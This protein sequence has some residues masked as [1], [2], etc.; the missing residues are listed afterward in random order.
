MRRLLLSVLSVLCISAAAFAQTRQLTGKVTGPDNQP[1]ISATLKVKGGST[2][3]TTN[4]DGLFSIKVPAGA[5]TL[6]I[7]SVGFAAKEV[8]FGSGESTLAITLDVKADNLSEV[9][10]TALGIKKRRKPWDTRFQK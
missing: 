4:A 10:V 3:T 8:S 5:G 6:Q 1:V 2:M 9:V 7:S